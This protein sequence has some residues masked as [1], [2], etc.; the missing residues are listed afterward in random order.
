[1]NVYSHC[2]R[3]QQIVKLE[4][5]DVWII[6]IIMIK[7]RRQIDYLINNQCYVHCYYT[8]ILLLY[9]LRYYTNYNA[10]AFEDGIGCDRQKW[11]VSMNCKEQ[12]FF[13]SLI[14]KLPDFVKFHAGSV[15]YSLK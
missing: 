10:T 1:M 8:K 9:Q 3:L 6:T 15:V 14:D 13:K 4:N 2:L 5:L 11:A 12:S 7:G